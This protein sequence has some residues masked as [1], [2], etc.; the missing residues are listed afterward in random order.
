[1]IESALH[2]LLILRITNDGDGAVLRAL[3]IAC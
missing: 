2:V 1:M 3:W